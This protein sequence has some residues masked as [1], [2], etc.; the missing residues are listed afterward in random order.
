MTEKIEPGQHLFYARA[1]VKK[2]V[3]QHGVLSIALF[4]EITNSGGIREYS[5][6]ELQTGEWIK[7]ETP[8]RLN[9][10]D[11]H[12]PILILQMRN[13]ISQILIDDVSLHKAGHS[14]YFWDASL[15]QL[16]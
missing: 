12:N 13:G 14:P 11:P 5:L 4:S 6:A 9:T 15:T 8:V 7:I 1:Y 10:E 3:G 2:L 16:F